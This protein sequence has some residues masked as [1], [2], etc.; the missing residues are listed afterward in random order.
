MLVLDDLGVQKS[1]DWA[2]MMVYSLISYR[3]DNLYV[4]IPK[5]ESWDDVY[6][7]I[8]CVFRNEDCEKSTQDETRL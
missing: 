4:F 2:F 6:K 3:Y 8:E 5:N 7:W 1:T